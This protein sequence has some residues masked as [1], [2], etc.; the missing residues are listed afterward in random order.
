MSSKIICVH[1]RQNVNPPKSFINYTQRYL[2]IHASK[3]IALLIND[4]V[5]TILTAEMK[6]HLL[7][8]ALIASIELTCGANILFLSG[9]PSPSHHIYNR[10]LILG[11]VDK[12]YNVTFL[13]A[14]D[15]K[16]PTTNIHYIHLEKVY[17]AFYNGE[18]A[19]D[20]LSFADQSPISAISDFP[21]MFGA[22][23]SGILESKGLNEIIAYP[24]DFKFDVV[25][26]DI[27]FGACLLPL[28]HKFN[29]P[30]LISI[31]AF[32]NPP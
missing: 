17:D 6:S 28:V 5:S 9:V 16:K 18:A 21:A 27:T 12:G 8:F 26:H 14:D 10:A 15:V 24:S 13:S 31:T 29:N 32:M 20:V 1:K 3:K 22:L 7:I 2:L 30:P 23:C 19:F 25:I 4:C 11:L